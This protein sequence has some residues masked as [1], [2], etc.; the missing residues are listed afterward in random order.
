MQLTETEYKNILQ[1]PLLP[2]QLKAKFKNEVK[3]HSWNFVG[4]DFAGQ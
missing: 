3:E 1:N 2:S 4:T